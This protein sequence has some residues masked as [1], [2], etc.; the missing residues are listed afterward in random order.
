MKNILA[1]VILAFFVSLVNVS[2]ANE[3]IK[4]EEPVI[5]KDIEEAARGYVSYQYAMY[6]MANVPEQFI[7]ES[8]QKMLS[9]RQQ[10][11]R[12]S[13]SVAE[14]KVITAVKDVISFDKKSISV[15]KF[16]ELK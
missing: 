14:Q 6:G 12:L 9:D 10:V 3:E 8:A 7:A 11:E 4:F 13:E 16:R 2:Y 1:G 15:E 5:E